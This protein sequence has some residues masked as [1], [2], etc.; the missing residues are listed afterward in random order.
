LP[1]ATVGRW[2]GIFLRMLKA[3]RDLW[4]SRLC[5]SRCLEDRA[6]GALRGDEYLPE[7][8]DAARRY[9]DGLAAVFADFARSLPPAPETGAGDD[10]GGPL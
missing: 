7:M 4:A 9:V 1:A 3:L 8:D 6:R 5:I 10:A 2:H